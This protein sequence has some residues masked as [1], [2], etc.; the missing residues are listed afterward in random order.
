MFRALAHVVKDVDARRVW[1]RHDLDE[2][3]RDGGR[4]PDLELLELRLQRR[5]RPFWDVVVAVVVAVFVAGVAALWVGLP[6][7][8][9][10]FGVAGDI[11][12]AAF[13]GFLFHGLF[14]LV[15]HEAT[16]GNLLGGTRDRFVGNVA[17]GL[18]LMP[19][20]A[21][22]YQ[23]THHVHHR[24]VNQHDDNNWTRHRDALFRRSRF[25]YV[26]YE[27]LPMLNNIDRLGGKPVRRR[28]RQVLASWAAAA[29]VVVACGPHPGWWLAVLVATNTVNAHRLW[30][31]HYGVFQG[32]VANT[33]AAPLSFGIGHHA[34]HHLRPHIPAPVLMVGLWFRRKDASLWT[35]LPR[36]LFDRRW[37]HFRLQQPDVVDGTAAAT[38]LAARER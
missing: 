16:H 35:A 38:S 31:E 5:L 24:L 13:A 6:A 21:E 12:L 25:L 37:L 15:V 26:L 30:I 32:Q 4:D 19:Y 8:L 14:I 34:L 11:A 1:C 28:R 18:L 7:L 2:L 27:L 36:V 29:F 23:H 22:S 9:G 33:Y 17:L 20:L 3:S 10:R